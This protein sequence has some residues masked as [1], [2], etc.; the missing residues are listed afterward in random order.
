MISLGMVTIQFQLRALATQNTVL[1]GV[2]LVVLTINF[3]P[4]IMNMKTKS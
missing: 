4:A 3:V 1:K 2:S